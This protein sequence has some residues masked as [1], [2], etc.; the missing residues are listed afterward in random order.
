MG[1]LRL[2]PETVPGGAAVAKVLSGELSI[3]RLLRGEGGAGREL[4][5]RGGRAP[6]CTAGSDIMMRESRIHS[7]CPPLLSNGCSLEG[8]MAAVRHRPINE[9]LDLNSVTCV[10]LSPIR[11]IWGVGGV[12]MA[13]SLSRQGEE[14]VPTHWMEL[15]EWPE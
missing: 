10:Q 9:S 11:H 8:F 15:P 12:E 13:Q 2:V 1:E 14:L 3:G 5:R 7:R 4:G 6:G